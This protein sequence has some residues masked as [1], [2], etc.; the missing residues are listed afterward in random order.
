MLQS[1]SLRPKNLIS[2]KASKVSPP[3]IR[4][5]K[6][7]S[8]AARDLGSSQV[9]ANIKALLETVGTANHI[10]FTAGRQATCHPNRTPHLENMQAAGLVRSFAA[11]LFAKIG[12]KHLS[13]SPASSTTFTSAIFA[14][15]QTANWSLITA[16]SAG[17]LRNGEGV[18]DRSEADQGQRCGAG[19][20]RDTIL[21]E[22][23][24][25]RSSSWIP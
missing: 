18:G 2:K 21:V 16:Y 15:K 24:G 10:V 25:C 5:P 22:L 9:G 14:K 23:S 13:P 19:G 20:C 7:G 8:R 3:T 12:P 6:I 11:I 4:P 17:D 1:S